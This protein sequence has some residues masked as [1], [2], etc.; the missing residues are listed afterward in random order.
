MK[1]ENLEAK[2]PSL[3][4]KS[5]ILLP[6]IF[7]LTLTIGICFVAVKD[8]KEDL[9]D[10]IVWIFFGV[11]IA[12]TTLAIVDTF[13]SKEK[14]KKLITFIRVMSVL[15]ILSTIAYIVLYLISK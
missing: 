5:Q 8:F 9:S 1:T 14:G 3:N 11:Y 13:I 6:V 12:Y 2:N 15:S 4:L 10:V 7:I